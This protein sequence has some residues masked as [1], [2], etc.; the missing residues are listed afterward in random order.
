M[1]RISKER[2][3]E[4]RQSIILEGRTLFFTKG[5]DKTSTK[6][7]AKKVGIAEGTLFNYFKDKNDLFL[8]AIASEFETV[9]ID[10]PY[11]YSAEDIAPEIIYNFLS[12]LY[13]PFMRLPKSMIIESGIA[14]VNVGKKHLPALKKLMEMDFKY[15]AKCKVVVDE[16]KDKGLFTEE[17]DT[18]EL[19][20][21]IFAVFLFEIFIYA[22]E[23]DMT[24]D[25]FNERF[26]KKIASVCKGYLKTV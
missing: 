18:Q 20:E 5:F 26:K 13:K 8:V 6:E 10:A 11:R 21:N 14:M 25:E 16:L 4:I 7:I 2:Q 19:T 24:R 3:E 9:D 22:Y 17:T 1:A 23:V 15:M 12:K